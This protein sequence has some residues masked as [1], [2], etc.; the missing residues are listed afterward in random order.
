MGKKAKE[1]IRGK[2]YLRTPKNIDPEKRYP[3]YIYYFCK[4][5]Q[6]RQKTDIFTR[7][8]DW[9]PKANDGIGALKASYGKNY[10]KDNKRLQ[11]KLQKLD[12]AIFEYIGKGRT[13]TSEVIKKFLAGDKK[14][15]RN[16]VGGE[17]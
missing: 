3:V 5:K 16:R 9:D 13:I 17:H 4:G 15:L 8:K 10:E 11:I 6:L 2:L 1:L 14:P 7:V 12:N